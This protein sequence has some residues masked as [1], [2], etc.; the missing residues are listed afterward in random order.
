MLLWNGYQRTDWEYRTTSSRC[1]SIAA[2]GILADGLEAQ[3][4]D[5]VTRY[6]VEHTA[7]DEQI[8]VVPWAAGFYFLTDRSNPTRTDF[9]LFE[10]P[11]VVSVRPR[12]LEE[13]PPNT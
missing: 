7:P 6:I 10:D 9:M 13:H 1:E 11:G 4:I 2:R 8:F 3:R 12:R 5:R